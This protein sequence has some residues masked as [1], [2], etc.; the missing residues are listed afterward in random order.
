MGSIIL[1]LWKV[2]L[3]PNI[4]SIQEYV[5]CTL[6]RN[7]YSAVV[8]QISVGL[9]CVVQIF[10]ALLTFY[11]VVVYIIESR[12]LASPIID[13]LFISPFFS[14][15]FVACILKIC[16]Q[17][18]ICLKSLCLTDGLTLLSSLAQV[19]QSEANVIQVQGYL[20]PAL[21][22]SA[23]LIITFNCSSVDI[24]TPYQRKSQ[25]RCGGKR[26]ELSLERRKELNPLG[27]GL[28]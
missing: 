15:S 20:L 21:L 17:V 27:G 9:V 13:E 1:N 2:V 18:H 10:I 19:R 25:C 3:C 4:W 6:E 24:T 7:M 5:V 16:S 8:L 14:V 26:E 11:L 22:C 12:V 28:Q 23:Q